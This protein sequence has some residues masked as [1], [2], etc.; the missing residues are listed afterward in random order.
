MEGPES[1][2]GSRGRARLAPLLRRGV[3]G[4]GVARR[5]CRGTRERLGGV[6]VAAHRVEGEAKEQE[7]RGTTR[8]QPAG[9]RELVGRLLRPSALEM[10][11]AQRH[12]DVRI[13]GHLLERSLVGANGTVPPAERLGHA[14][15]G[16]A[17]RRALVAVRAGQRFEQAPQRQHEIGSRLTDAGGGLARSRPTARAQSPVVALMR[18]LLR[19]DAA[20]ASPGVSRNR[21]REQCAKTRPASRTPR[22][23]RP[24][25]APCHQSPVFGR[26]SVFGGLQAQKRQRRVRM[27]GPALSSV[28]RPVARSP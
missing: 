1:F 14:G 13:A 8:R 21:H 5:Q 26:S 10:H 24:T 11:R 9:G 2:D 27:T 28:Y 7:H 6:G 20:G 25:S 16:G 22:I 3:R 12:V 17:Q 18:R 23:L 19:V 4:D 15:S